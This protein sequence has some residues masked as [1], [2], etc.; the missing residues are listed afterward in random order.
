MPVTL[1]SKNVSLHKQETLGDTQKCECQW[2]FTLATK[3]C[4]ISH[5]EVC[6]CHSAIQGDNMPFKQ[7]ETMPEMWYQESPPHTPIPSPATPPY[8]AACLAPHTLPTPRNI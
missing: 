7:Q 5:G 2:N 3:V 6:H 4:I 1:A 8:E